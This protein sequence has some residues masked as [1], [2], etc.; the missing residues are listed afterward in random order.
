[1]PLFFISAIFAVSRLAYWLGRLLGAGAAVAVGRDGSTRASGAGVGSSL[2]WLGRSVWS[3]AI[4]A[5]TYGVVASISPRLDTFLSVLGSWLVLLLLPRRTPRIFLMAARLV[6][7]A[8]SISALWSSWNWVTMRWPV[9]A[10]F[11]GVFVLCWW[12]IAAAMLLWS[13]AT[14]R[15]NAHGRNAIVPA[16]PRP[17]NSHREAIPDSFDTLEAQTSHTH[18]SGSLK[19]ATRHSQVTISG[20]LRRENQVL[21]ARP[22]YRK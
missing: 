12:S 6:V 1:M 2:G 15:R 4:L 7:M 8:T 19:W 16:I 18:M 13:L 11:D 22:S 9:V 10:A 17:M 20:H 21:T 5:G 14:L 3:L